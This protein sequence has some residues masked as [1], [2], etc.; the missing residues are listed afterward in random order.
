[1]RHVLERKDHFVIK[2]EL[3]FDKNFDKKTT[4]L[5]EYDSGNVPHLDVEELK[6]LMK[7]L[8]WIV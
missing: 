8:K 1:M 7:K 3:E 2:R 4:K 6:L 5:K